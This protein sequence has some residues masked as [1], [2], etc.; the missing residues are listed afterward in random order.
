MYILGNHWQNGYLDYHRAAGEVRI[1]VRCWWPLETLRDVYLEQPRNLRR[2]MN[3][4]REVGVR[5]VWRKIRSRLAES[6]R[7]RRVIA[8]GVGEIVESDDAAPARGTPVLFLAPCHPPCVERVCVP[9]CCVRPIPPGLAASLRRP[10]AIL[11]MDAARSTGAPGLAE[12]AGWSRYSG[13]DIREPARLLLDW[14]LDAIRRLDPR[15]GRALPLPAATPIMERSAHAPGSGISGVLFGLGN[16]AKTVILPN[17]DPRIR[18][19]CIHEIDPTQIGVVKPGRVAFD[20]SPEARPDERYDFWAIAG[21][22]HTHAALS[23][24]ALRQGAA[25]VSEKPLVTTRAE[26]DSLLSA[27]RAGPGRYFAGFHMRYSPLWPLAFEDLGR[28]PGEPIHYSCIVFEVPLVRRHWYNWPTSRS[29]VV[30]NGCHWLDHFLYMNAFSPPR[31]KH[32]WRA[33]NDDIHVSVELENGAVMSMALTDKGSRRIGVQDH[34]QLRAGEVTVRV[35]NQS[36]YQSEDR[37]RI[38]RRRRINKMSSLRNLYQVASRRFL[39]NEPGDPVESTRISSELML[40]LDEMFA[41]R[42]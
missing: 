8:L 29:R 33:G 18:I 35:E 31:R 3:Y 11:L 30:S 9:D 13:A 34:I 6:L 16:Y 17:L 20:T 10:E 27:I 32:L 14:G 23:V 2:V 28:E 5:E 39:Q 4:V 36:A 1:A 37:F 15:A 21:F 19:A 40:E 38:L 25:V 7:D 42:T 12:A 22:H 24:H 26:L 41:R